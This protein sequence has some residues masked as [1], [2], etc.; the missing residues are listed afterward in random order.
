MGKRILVQRRGRGGKQFQARKTGK[1]DAVRYPLYPLNEEHDG[2]VLELLH[3]RGREAPLAKIEFDDGKISYL[4]AVEGL[5]VGKNIKVA[6]N[7]EP[8][9]MNIMPLATIP[10]GTAI[11]CIEKNFGDGGKL[12]RTA[13]SYATI[14][15]HASNFVTVRLPSGKFV[16]LDPKCRAIIGVVAGGGRLEKPLLKAGKNYHIARAKGRKYPKVRGVAMAVVF[17]P[18]GG[19]RHQH[20]GRPTTVSRNT[21]PGRKVGYIAARKTGR[22]RVR[23]VR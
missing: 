2:K 6:A 7:V 4:P 14:F 13:G 15:G 21:P 5:E 9:L 12:V 16:Q 20:P 10:D 22:T 17:H 18:H 11:C 1:I 3:E 8:S 19:G 23:K